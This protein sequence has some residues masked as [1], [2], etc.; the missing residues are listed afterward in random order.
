MDDQAIVAL[1]WARDE[2]AIEELSRKYSVYCRSIA[3]NILKDSADAEECVNDTWLSTWN[4]LP[5]RKPALLSAY[6]A[7]I[8]RNLS[9]SR[10]RADH[11]AKRGGRSLAFS[12]EEL[13]ESVPDSCS[14]EDAVS[15]RELGTLLDQFLRSLPDRDC[16]LFLRRYW[17]Y[18]TI[19]QIAHRY[20]M[21]EG[22]VKTRL[23]RI[24]KKLKLYL[25]QEGYSL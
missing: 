16:C 13:Q 24:R 23:H 14:A 11:A 8:T 15:A 25:E 1:F 6:V 20:G 18:D 19:T 22:T 7:A 17:Y 2:R 10:Y 4:S 5:P 9:L 3:R 12:Y 21:T